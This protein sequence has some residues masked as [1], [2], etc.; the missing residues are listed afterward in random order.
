MLSAD[1]TA[2]ATIDNF[3]ISATIHCRVAREFNGVPRDVLRAAF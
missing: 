1:G 3:Y 2:H